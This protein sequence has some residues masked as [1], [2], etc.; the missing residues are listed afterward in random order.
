MRAVFMPLS[1]GVL[2]LTAGHV[3][4][5]LTLLPAVSSSLFLLRGPPK[6][7]KL[8]ERENPHRITVRLGPLLEIT[9]SGYGVVAVFLGF[10]GYAIGRACGLW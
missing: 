8:P 3:G 9:G 5:L 6:V 1:W 10:V 7:S 2:A 4:H